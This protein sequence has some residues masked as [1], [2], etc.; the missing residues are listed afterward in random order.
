MAALVIEEISKRGRGSTC[1]RA[2]KNE[3]SGCRPSGPTD[4]SRLSHLPEFEHYRGCGSSPRRR[5]A[6]S[7]TR[8]GPAPRN[9]SAGGGREHSPGSALP[10]LVWLS[11]SLGTLS[12]IFGKD[13]KNFCPFVTKDLRIRITFCLLTRQLGEEKQPLTGPGNDILKRIELRPA[14]REPTPRCTARGARP[15]PLGRRRRTSPRHDP[16]GSSRA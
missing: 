11:T 16:A 5:A 2:I 7:Q 12:D 14:S 9:P 3:T 15:S 13:W 6:V 4:W 1:F 10:S 8:Y